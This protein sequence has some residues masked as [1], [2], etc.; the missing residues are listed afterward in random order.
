MRKCCLCGKEFTGWGNNPWPVDKD[1][2]HKCCNKCDAEKV[3][4]ARIIMIKNKEE[5]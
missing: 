1:P 3:I 5:K 4:P 2:S